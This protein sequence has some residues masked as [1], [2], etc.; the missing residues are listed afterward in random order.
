MRSPPILFF[1]GLLLSACSGDPMAPAGIGSLA[2][3]IQ[4]TGLDFDP[5]GYHL[6][7]DGTMRAS[8]GAIDTRT[9][10]RLEPG[11]HAV[12]LADLAANCTVHGPQSQT[13]SI[14]QQETQSLEFAVVCTAASG[15]IRV[16]VAATG[17]AALG[18]YQVS[19]DGAAGHRVQPGTPAYLPAVSAGDHSV[20]L[21]PPGNCSVQGNPRSATI[22][23]G[24]LTRDTA[25]VAFDAACV[26]MPTALR[27]TV[28]TTGVVPPDSSGFESSFEVL[29]WGPNPGGYPAARGW[30]EPNGTL[31][32]P[33]LPGQYR[34]QLVVPSICGVTVPNPTPVFTVAVGATVD[35]D[36]PVQCSPSWDY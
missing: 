19:V 29:L 2:V 35:L 16:V 7:V 32:T 6:T 23:V 18:A 30:V 15:V 36:I 9:I 17:A 8:A 11:S 14:T 28:P 4:T 25:E 22:T 34:L 31:M 10:T 5:D 13:V 20:S 33:V 26:P 24:S 12:G 27:V 3:S 21:V 1:S